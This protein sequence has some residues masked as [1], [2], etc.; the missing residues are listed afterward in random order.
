MDEL[1]GFA[2]EGDMINTEKLINWIKACHNN[3]SIH[4]FDSR[5]KKFIK[6]IGT[7]KCTDVVLVYIVKDNHY[8]PITNERLK[9][10]ASKA[11]RG[12]CNYLLKHM[13]DL[14][15]TKRHENVTKIESIVEI[16]DFRRITL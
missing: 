3:F 6:H 10:I 1:C 15:W 5:Y 9:L 2:P 11:N 4:A 8:F 13:T 16:N 12:V 7:H 14:K